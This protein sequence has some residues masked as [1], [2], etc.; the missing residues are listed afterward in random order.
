MRCKVVLAAALAVLVAFPATALATWG[1]GECDQTTT[2]HC[3]A[4]DTWRMTGD[5]Q[6]EGTEA[7]EDTESMNVSEWRTGAFIDN[8][9]WLSFTAHENWWAEVGQTKNKLGEQLGN[10]EYGT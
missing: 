2:G 4:R 10:I 8:E 6:V 1:D 7:F 3:Y 9:E 5:E